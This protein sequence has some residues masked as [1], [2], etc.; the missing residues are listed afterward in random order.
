MYV[1][2][3]QE[4]C[5]RGMKMRTRLELGDRSPLDPGLDVWDLPHPGHQVLDLGALVQAGLVREAGAEV[6]GQNIRPGEGI[7]GKVLSSPAA[8]ASLQLGEPVG[9]G[10]SHHLLL[11]SLIGAKM[12]LSHGLKQISYSVHHLIGLGSLEVVSASQPDL[13]GDEPGDGHGLRYLAPVPLQQGQR[14]VRGLGLERHPL[15][16]VLD[17]AV[18]RSIGS[19][20]DCTITEKAP[21]RAFSWLKAPTSAFTFKTLLRHYAKRA[22]T[23]RSLN[24]KLGPRHNYHKGRA[25]IRHYANQ[26]TRSL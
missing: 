20:I 25:A 19:I 24:V 9:N 16:R 5:G 1:C 6:V 2:S 4:C 11:Q 10:L 3:M 7:A 15:G 22:L 17:S 18:K 13:L 12:C 8:E 23:P 21:T 14:P 26:T